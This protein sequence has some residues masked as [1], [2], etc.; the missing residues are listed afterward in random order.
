MNYLGVFEN[1]SLESDQRFGKTAALPLRGLVGDDFDDGALLLAG[2]GIC[3]SWKWNVA[4]SHFKA[5]WAEHWSND[6]ERKANTIHQKCQRFREWRSGRLECVN[7]MPSP[8][9]LM[10]ITRFST[11]FLELFLEM[12]RFTCLMRVLFW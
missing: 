2:E 9:A 10:N 6:G 12:R 11:C 8:D 5:L 1:V 4:V 3:G 7:R